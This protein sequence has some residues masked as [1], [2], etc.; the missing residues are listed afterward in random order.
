MG[1]RWPHVGL[2]D[3]LSTATQSD[4]GF[5][6]QSPGIVR[7]AGAA[8]PQFSI[9][10][11]S[12]MTAGFV[13]CLPGVNVTLCTD[14]SG[15]TIL[16]NRSQVSFS[17]VSE[18]VRD[19]SDMSQSNPMIVTTTLAHG[20]TNLMK[21]R[22]TNQIGMP[23]YVSVFEAVNVLDAF[24][25]ELV[26]VD[27]SAYSPY[28][29]GGQVLIQQLLM[30]GNYR[31]TGAQSLY[32]DEFSVP[33]DAPNRV[34]PVGSL[35]TDVPKSPEQFW[36]QS[37]TTLDYTY[38]IGGQAAG[39]PL[40][41]PWV[42]DEEVLIELIEAFP[43]LPVIPDQDHADHTVVYGYSISI[44]YGDGPPDPDL[45]TMVEPAGATVTQALQSTRGDVQY[46]FSPADVGTT[47]TFTVRVENAVGVDTASWGVT[48]LA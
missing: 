23:E 17:E 8:A 24:R 18:L 31:M 12:Y 37:S 21:V 25:F 27:S 16:P 36:G 15:K 9:A 45:W 35:L 32:V 46:T 33:C 14:L 11:A 38:H 44:G 29:S 4:G 48:V 3:A 28:I 39:C 2:G 42:E 20:L 43:A 30:W 6:V 22:I 19:V 40:A 5:F 1:A 26:G 7:E 34:A 41:P 10:L 47:V 13:A